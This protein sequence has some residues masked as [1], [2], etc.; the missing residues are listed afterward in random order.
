MDAKCPKCGHKDPKWED[1]QVIY[2]VYT[3]T[4][5]HSTFRVTTAEAPDIT[6]E[7]G[8]KVTMLPDTCANCGEK[9]VAYSHSRRMTMGPD[10]DQYV[11]WDYLLCNKCGALTQIGLFGDII[12]L[13]RSH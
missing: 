6:P 8:H 1:C 9:T 2:N 10:P 7:S 11:A 5:C 4:N 13:N 12:A 3:C